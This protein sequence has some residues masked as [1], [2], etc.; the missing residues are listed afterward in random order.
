M[1]SFVLFGLEVDYYGPGHLGV[2]GIAGVASMPA[3]FKVRASDS[4]ASKLIGADI[5]SKETQCNVLG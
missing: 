2:V 3:A 1:T 4:V 5:L